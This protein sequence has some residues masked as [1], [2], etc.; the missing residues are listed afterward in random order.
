M[1]FDAKGLLAPGN[2]MSLRGRL[3]WGHQFTDAPTATAAFTS[4]ANLPFTVTGAQQ[5]R[6][7]LLASAAAE[8]RFDS[9]HVL[10]ARFDTEL[11]GNSQSYG[12]QGGYR[13]TW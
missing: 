5:D 12:G 2:T 8:W 6:D 3:A 1:W 4:I 11:S 13:W 7:A 10:F 9:S